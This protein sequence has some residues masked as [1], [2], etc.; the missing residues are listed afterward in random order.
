MSPSPSWC[1]T[2]LQ[3]WQRWWGAAEGKTRP[4]SKPQSERKPAPAHWREPQTPASQMTEPACWTRCPQEF[5][6]EKTTTRSCSAFDFNVMLPVMAQSSVP[7]G[8]FHQDQHGYVD[9]EVEQRQLVH[10]L[11]N[12]CFPALCYPARM[13]KVGFSLVWWPN[14]SQYFHLTIHLF[15]FASESAFWRMRAHK[16]NSA[17]G[18]FVI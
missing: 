3:T 18:A 17:F 10:L 16:N 4:P 13:T 2:G 15:T 5:S 1:K 12:A 6:N 9:E 7:A 14:V 8:E 11:T